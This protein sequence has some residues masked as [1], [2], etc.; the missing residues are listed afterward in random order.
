MDTRVWDTP[1]S[2]HITVLALY[3]VTDGKCR[4]TV[5]GRLACAQWLSAP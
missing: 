2:S 5:G 4:Q 3:E 1:N